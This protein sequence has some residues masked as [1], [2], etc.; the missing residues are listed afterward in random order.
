MDIQGDFENA[1]SIEGTNKPGSVLIIRV[2]DLGANIRTL[3]EGLISV[4]D[5][6]IFR[7]TCGG[8]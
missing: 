4:S 3:I 5:G 2:I 6:G 7:A 1:M 8:C